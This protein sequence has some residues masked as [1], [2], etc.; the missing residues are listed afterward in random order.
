MGDLP[1]IIFELG[2]SQVQAVTKM[3][4]D[5]GFGSIKVHQDMSHKDR[6]ITAK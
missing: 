4:A 5:S 1:R 2:V 6:W 3:L